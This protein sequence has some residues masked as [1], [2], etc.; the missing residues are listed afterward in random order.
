MYPLTSEEV[1][2][3][4]YPVRCPPSASSVDWL[5]GSEMLDSLISGWLRQ[6]PSLPSLP[7]ID[8]SSVHQSARIKSKTSSIGKT[9]EEVIS[10]EMLEY[11]EIV[12]IP[13]KKRYAI[14]IRVKEIR[15]AVPVIT[16]PD[17]L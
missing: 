8:S 6:K 12:H 10:E 15:K 11:D 4:D 17:E 7:E 3:P 14:N 2:S 1:T 16:T 5:D 9:F 13:P